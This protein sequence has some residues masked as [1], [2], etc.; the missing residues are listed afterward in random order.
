MPW[1]FRDYPNIMVLLLIKIIL[2][3]LTKDDIIF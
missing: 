2:E 3:I 1:I